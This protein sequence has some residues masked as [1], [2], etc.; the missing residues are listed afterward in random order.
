MGNV[1]NYSRH[2]KMIAEEIMDLCYSEAIGETIIPMEIW[3]KIGK[4]IED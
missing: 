4:Y 1:G 2:I 3:E